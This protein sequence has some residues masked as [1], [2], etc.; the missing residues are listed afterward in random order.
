MAT[1]SD[2]D[3]KLRDLRSDFDLMRDD[4]KS[5][6]QQIAGLTKGY[7]SKGAERAQQA[8]EETKERIDI[9]D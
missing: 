2:I 9:G 7:A 3:E 4:L 6:G 1:G 5:L 8:A